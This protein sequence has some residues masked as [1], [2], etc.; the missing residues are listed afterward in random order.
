M[1]DDPTARAMIGYLLVRGGVHS[2][3]TPARWRS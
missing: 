2:S 3:P 1:T